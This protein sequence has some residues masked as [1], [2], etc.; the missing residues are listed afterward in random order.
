[1]SEARS[2][3][4]QPVEQPQ[5]HN[6]APHHKPGVLWAIFL[7]IAIILGYPLSIGPVAR[8]YKGGPP[9][10]FVITLYTPLWALCDRNKV[11]GHALSG[12]LELW[13]IHADRD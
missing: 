1:M 11:A 7:L 12:Y 4:E 10:D 3:V 2:E 9:P 8:F 5:P 6:S 13:G